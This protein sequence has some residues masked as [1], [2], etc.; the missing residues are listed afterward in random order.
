MK[1]SEELKK[2]AR[3]LM[4]QAVEMEK[5]EKIERAIRVAKVLDDYLAN[6]A[7]PD[8]VLVKLIKEIDS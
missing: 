3:E 1:K 6:T 7:N 5:R 8:P 4:K 2:R